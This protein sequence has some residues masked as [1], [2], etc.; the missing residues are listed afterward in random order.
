MIKLE[1]K[2]EHS[3][4]QKLSMYDA[5]A[6]RPVHLTDLQTIQ[7]RMQC[8]VA[9]VQDIAQLDLVFFDFAR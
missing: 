8:S 9:D 5:I 4:D 6:Q 3:H 2:R 1:L 7:L